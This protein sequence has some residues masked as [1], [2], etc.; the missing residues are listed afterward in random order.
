[1]AGSNGTGDYTITIPHGLLADTSL[2]NFTGSLNDAA[3]MAQSSINVVYGSGYSV[4]GGT[5]FDVSTVLLYSQT[6]FRTV[7]RNQNSSQAFWSQSFY[8]M[9]TYGFTF[10]VSI[11][12]STWNDSV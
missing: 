11:P 12:I 2:V 3:A 8:G 7:W 4:S 9:G 1:V 6:S 5:I 10:V